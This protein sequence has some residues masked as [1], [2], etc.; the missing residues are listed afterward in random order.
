[1][2]VKKISVLLLLL[3]LVL[4]LA[5]CMPPPIFFEASE[6]AAAQ[7]ADK[8]SPPQATDP[9]QK[10]NPPQTAEQP[11]HNN[12][13]QKILQLK[14]SGNMDAMPALITGDFNADGLDDVCVTWSVFG[15]KEAF[16]AQILLND[17][18]GGLYVG[19]SDIVESGTIE[20]EFMHNHMVQMALDDFNMDG[21]GDI[22]I[23][24]AGMDKDPFPGYQN[25]LFLSAQNGKLADATEN[26]P[27]LHDNPHTIATADVDGDGD[28]DIYVGNI[29]AGE[30]I[31]PQLL[32]N[33]GTG[34]FIVKSQWL[35]PLT[36]LQQNGYTA[37]AFV[38]V[39]ND[40]FPDLILGDAGDT[41]NNK[42][43][44]PDSQV[45]INNGEGK[46]SPLK[47][48]IPEKPSPTCVALDIAYADLNADNYQ[49]LIMVY[50]ESSYIG[51][52]FQVLINNRDG[53]FT[54]ETA[55]R[56][57]DANEPEGSNGYHLNWLDIDHD[58]D[59]DLVVKLWDDQRPTPLLFINDNGFFTEDTFELQWDTIYYT[60]MDIDG[61]GGNDLV[62]LYYGR[63]TPVYLLR[64]LN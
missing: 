12:Q 55:R 31:N 44:S 38:D 22:F 54:D 2:I 64:D 25:A 28:I 53:T 37:S 34:R 42:Y 59:L 24:I 51:R 33:D 43:S 17:G 36:R 14:N 29:W 21:V 10:E 49:D 7:P 39:N 11:Q 23:G 46:F 26:L 18:E 9:P 30:M 27:Q 52:F 57:P 45:L 35:P 8:T 3:T 4:A 32:I 15:R 48:A 58:N 63:S 56:L 6:P 16:E 5:S 41:I 50:T 47:N 62:Y 40:T 60:F 1:M 61:D 19:T 20:T 13:P